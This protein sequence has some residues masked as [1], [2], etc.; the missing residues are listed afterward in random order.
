MKSFMK[1]LPHYL[2]LI[3]VLVTG[4]VLFWVFSYDKAFQIAV[5][6]ALAV[7]YVA[8]GVVHHYIHRDLHLSVIIEYIVIA[9]LGLVVILSLIFRA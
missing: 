9:S 8:W 5:A 4:L 7:S 2:A 3:G 1:H 6:I